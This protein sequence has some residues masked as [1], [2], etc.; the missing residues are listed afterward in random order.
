[1]IGGD[2]GAKRFDLRTHL[3][4]QDLRPAPQ[5]MRLLIGLG[6][7]LLRL[8]LSQKRGGDD[9]V[10]FGVGLH[11]CLGINLAKLEA[12][13]FV[14]RLLDATTS[15]SVAAPYAYTTIPMRGPLPV[16]IGK[17]A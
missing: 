16:V 9:R 2:A 11:H 8:R 6:G 12:E 7:A 4:A 10:G 13:V 5:E 3:L 14:A 15:F 17:D 1:M